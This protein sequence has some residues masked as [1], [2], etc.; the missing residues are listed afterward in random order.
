MLEA[1]PLP[2]PPITELNSVSVASA[3]FNVAV[4]QQ[5]TEDALVNGK[6]E[7]YPYKSA[8]WRHPL[9]LYVD[10]VV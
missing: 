7:E 10:G 8:G 9:V 1:S 2:C 4:D 3:T 5:S 6:Q